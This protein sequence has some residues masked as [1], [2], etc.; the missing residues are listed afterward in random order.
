MIVVALMFVIVGVAG[1]DKI[2]LRTLQSIYVL[3]TV[4]SNEVFIVHIMECIYGRVLDL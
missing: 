4:S 2:T 3:I 1:S